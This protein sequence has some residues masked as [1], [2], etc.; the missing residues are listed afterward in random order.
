MR[1]LGLTQA[2]TKVVHNISHGGAE[3]GLIEAHRR[4]TL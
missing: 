3:T 1:G 4:R 2:P